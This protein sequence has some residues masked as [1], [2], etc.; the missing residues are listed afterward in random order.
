[1]QISA[2]TTVHPLLLQGDDGSPAYVVHIA[3]APLPGPAWLSDKSV[4]GHDACGAIL[5]CGQQPGPAWLECLGPRTVWMAAGASAQQDLALLRQALLDP[6]QRPGLYGVDRADY[7]MALG[8]GRQIVVHSV[9]A[10]GA[11][12]AIDKLGEDLGCPVALCLHLRMPPAAGLPE[13]DQTVL[14]IQ[15]I[16]GVMSNDPPLVL[17]A[18]CEDRRDVQATLLVVYP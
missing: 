7:A 18:H 2:V 6:V 16:A 13:V 9:S 11:R 1:M 3:G 17:A 12:Q 5:V 10:S 8:L 15:S 4:S 14:A